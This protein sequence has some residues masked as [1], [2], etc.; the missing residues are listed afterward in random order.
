MTWYLFKHR[1]NFTFLPNVTIQWTPEV[2]RRPTWKGGILVPRKAQ[3]GDEVKREKPCWP[4]VSGFYRITFTILEP[5]RNDYYDRNS[6][7]FQQLS[8]DLSQAVNELYKGVE[9]LQ[10]A[11]VIQI[12]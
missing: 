12:R 5:F 8:Q 2:T 4:S 6:E 3:I 1:D 9:G 7:A 10:S 11:T